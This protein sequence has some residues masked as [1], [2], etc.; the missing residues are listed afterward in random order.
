MDPDGQ[1]VT[2][3]FD[4]LDRDEQG[5]LAVSLNRFV[6]DR[7]PE[8]E[9]REVLDS[10]LFRDITTAQLAERLGLSPNAIA[11][12]EL[13]RLWHMYSLW[14]RWAADDA[15]GWTANSK[16]ENGDGE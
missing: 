11:E 16:S 10:I 1:E 3:A 15:D 4:R 14:Y 6:I 13:N 9:V 7:V 2:A 8:S 5:V 12:P